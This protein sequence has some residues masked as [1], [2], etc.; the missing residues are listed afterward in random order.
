MKKLLSLVTLAFMLIS[1]IMPF[2]TASAD[3]N[4]PPTFDSL[5]ISKKQVELFDPIEFYMV[6]SGSPYFLT[7]ITLNYKKPNGELYPIRL[8][9]DGPMYHYSLT[10]NFSNEDDIGL[11]TL[12]SIEMRDDGDNHNLL[13]KDNFP[14]LEEYN[15]E[16]TP[17]AVDN[18]NP[19]IHS[20]SF[21]KNEINAGEYN[22]VYVNAQDD[23]GISNV[24]MMLI[25]PSGKKHIEIYNL[26]KNSNGLWENTFEVPAY[27]EKGSWRVEYVN[28][29]DISGNMVSINTNESYPE[30]FSTF[31]VISEN[32]DIDAPV[33]KS[34]NIEKNEMN[35]DETNTIKV[36]VSDN[37]SGISEM[38]V[39]FGIDKGENSKIYPT[40]CK[41]TESE[42]IYDCTLKVPYYLASGDYQ[43]IYAYA[44]DN[45]N[46]FINLTTND[47]PVVGTN[48]IKITNPHED[49]TP[50]QFNKL[51]LPT[52][53]IKL[54]SPINVQIDTKDIGAGVG[55]MDIMFENEYG[56]QVYGWDFNKVDK[57]TWSTDMYVY[58]NF[59]EGTYKIK[60][61]VIYDNAGNS[62]EI[63]Y[64]DN[65]VIQHKGGT[66]TVLENAPVYKFTVIKHST[67]L[68]TSRTNVKVQTYGKQ[69]V[70]IYNGN[71]LLGSKVS[72]AY[73]KASISYSA[74]QK[75]TRLKVLIKDSEGN[76]IE[77]FFTTVGVSETDIVQPA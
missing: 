10:T 41:Q 62:T 52:K 46:N 8:Y 42:S 53:A 4:I 29:W 56:D 38:E 72:N 5:T 23:S 69:T 9:H 45:A 34:L 33:I 51:V 49:I 70:E 32:E 47:I 58:G 61:I 39:S 74:L 73:G 63:E 6:Q 12:E 15:F 30:N 48:L 68:K 44:R 75:N 65:G 54:D 28:A 18:T 50:P 35:A 77:E 59:H 11:W 40:E 21:K 37:N 60:F 26:S 57:N 71:N 31:Q 17:G 76:I 1:L 43:I 27:T 13:T 7:D 16:I 22:T 3:E 24:S 67:S 36:S 2:N 19:T 14:S 20:I 66:S 55:A 25:S 64:T